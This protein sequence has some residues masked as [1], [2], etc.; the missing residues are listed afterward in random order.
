MSWGVD[1]VDMLKSNLF[2][3]AARRCTYLAYAGIVFNY[4][5]DKC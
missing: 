5:H 3:R 4:Y 2:G 1:I